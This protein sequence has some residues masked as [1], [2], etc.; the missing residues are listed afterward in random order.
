MK[1]FK[2]KVATFTAML[3]LLTVSCAAVNAAG[4]ADNT[5]LGKTGNMDVNK[6][7]TTRMDVNLKSGKHGDVGQVDWSKFNV[8]SGERVNFGFSGTS[9]T[10]IN[11][12]LGGQKSSILGQLTNSCTVGD[13]AANAAT[14]KVILINPA[15][16]MFGAGSMVDLNSFTVSTFDFN[17]AKNL[18]NMSEADIEAY[19]TGTLNKFSPIKVVPAGENPEDYILN[20]GDRGRGD[21]YFDSNYTQE[22]TNAGINM[23]EF[24]GKTSVELNG[25]KFGHF[26]TDAEGNLSGTFAD[27]NPNK[28][29]NVISD[30]ITYKDSLI[31]TGGNFNYDPYGDGRDV[32]SNSNVKLITAD[33]VT[34]GYVAN[35]YTSNT[36]VANDSKTNV[37]RNIVMDNSNIADGTP[38][39]ETGDFVAYN[40]SNAAGSD[41]NVRET[42]IKADKLFNNTINGVTNASQGGEY[43]DVL[44]LGTGDINIEKSRIETANTELNGKT[45]NAQAGGEIQIVSYGNTKIEDSLIKSA[46]VDKANFVDTK[47]IQNNGGKN[48]SSE[49]KI[50]SELGQVDITGSRIISEEN[51][52]VTGSDGVNFTDSLLSAKNS[53]DGGARNVNITSYGNNININDGAIQGKDITLEAYNNN[54]NIT[55]SSDSVNYASGDVVN[56][57]NKSLLKAQNDLN[58]KAANTKIEDSSLAYNNLNLYDNTHTNNVT[59]AGNVTLTPNAGKDLNIETNGNLTFD[60][61]DVYY[62]E[63]ANIGISST[64]NGTVSAIPYNVTVKGSKADNITGKSTKNNVNVTNSSD[65]NANQDINLIAEKG[66]VNIDNSKVNADRD[67]NITA[68]NT[69]AFGTGKNITPTADIDGGRN[70]NITSTNGDITAEKTDMPEIEYGNRLTFDAARDN[71]FTSQNSLKSV[72]VDYKAGRANKFYTEGDNQFVNSTFEAPENFVESG[73]DVIL[74]NLEVKAPDGTTPKNVKTEIYANGNV[75]TDNVTNEDLTA[76]G[77]VFPQSVKTDR[78]GTQGTELDLNQTKLKVETQTVKDP[79]NPDNG[80]IKLDLRDANNPEAGLDLVAKNVDSL[81]KDSTD[82]NFRQG[83]FKSGDSKWDENIAPKEGPEVTLNAKDGSVSIANIETDKLNLDPNDKI[84]ADNTKGVPP[85]IEVKDQ[86]GFNLDPKLGYDDDPTNFKYDKHTDSDRVEEGGDLELDNWT[87]WKPTGKEWT[88][89]DGT[90][91]VEYEHTRDGR[92]TDKTITTTDRAHEI[93]FDNDGNPQEFKLVYEKQTVEE[94]PGREIK[95]SDIKDDP[96][97]LPEVKK[98]DGTPL[99]YSD[100]IGTKTEDIAHLDGDSYINMIKIPR[101]QLETSKTSKVTDNTVDQSANV[102]AAAA[103]VEI[104]EDGENSYDDDDEDIED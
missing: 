37:K 94:I 19:K 76:T 98:Q 55:S 58:I 40:Y 17:G 18:K 23:N 57:Q 13:C 34:F 29:V 73:H 3:A 86:G 62:G 12:V 97:K 93:T 10:I 16:V 26:T 67:A 36:K 20:G 59:V 9:Q 69:I 35:G 50:T 71:V 49:V 31:R 11:R 21:I 65:L 95:A 46:K 74:N 33:G 43:G 102:M 64:D 89:P 47:Y 100:I 25:T 39:V 87:E 79:S 63:T 28:T 60:N 75:T 99:K 101:Q 96:S 77:G 30:N 104:S 6:T 56:G 85:T 14:S 103:K 4:I 54:I 52:S 84:I 66:S 80:S 22:F 68:Y 42:Y 2:T 44:I 48:P 7:S 51:A 8:G 88:D 38:A 27:S 5:V 92:I 24:N 83:Y 45:T 32:S 1:K 72:N 41:V 15:G 90:R 78:T 61:A 70:V 81:K 82:G 53:I 91:H